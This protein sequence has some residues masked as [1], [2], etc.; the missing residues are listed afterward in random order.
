MVT[1]RVAFSFFH[2]LHLMKDEYKTLRRLSTGTYT[3]R[4]SKFIAYACP[5]YSAEQWQAH[6]NDLKKEHFKAVHYCF[7]FRLGT[8]NNNFR[9]NDDGEPSGSAGRPILGQIDRFGLTNVIVVVVRYWGGTKLG[10]P[11][12]INAYKSSTAEALKSAEIVEKRI[13]D[14]FRISFDYAL[15]SNVM[16][17]VKKAGIEMISQD[18]GN[19]ASLEV[20]IRKSEAEVTCNQIRA[21]VAGVRIEEQEKWKKI[22]GFEMK[23]LETR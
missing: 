23:Y 2:T 9:A 10:V 22:E 11:G 14:I 12:L 6:V 7:A 17:A 20:A 19:E 8:D 16:N 13:E 21:L 4:G 5:V 1:E 3:D 18:F 15:M